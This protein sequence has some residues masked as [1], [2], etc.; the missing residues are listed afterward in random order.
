MLSR[1]TVGGWLVT[2]AALAIALAA[3]AGAATEGV[4]GVCPPSAYEQPFAPWLDFAS[5]VLAPNG[6]LES[7]AAG[8]SLDGGAA[9]VAGNESF[10][11]RGADDTSSL[12]LPAGSTATT[13]SMCVDATSP[14]LRFFVRNSGS[15]L[16][17]LKVEALYT[18]A[19]GQPRALPVALLAAGPS[20]QP[21]LPVAFLTNFTAPPLVTDGTTSVTFRFTPQGSWSGWKIDDVYVD[22][23]K[24]E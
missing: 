11:V 18:D 24:G 8:W 13:S 4:V 22:P 19:L 20:W 12:S 2:V 6:G 3:P 21:T 14:D 23:F 10:Y 7:G 5:Y 1:G 16:S 17:T 9:V 15:L